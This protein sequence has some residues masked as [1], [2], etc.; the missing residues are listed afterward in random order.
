L[1]GWEV[2]LERLKAKNRSAERLD[3]YSPKFRDHL[4]PHSARGVARHHASRARQLHKRPLT[5]L[6]AY[7]AN[8][9]TRLAHAIYNWAGRE[10]GVETEIESISGADLFN[11]EKDRRRA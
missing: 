1:E 3:D 7:F 4:A 2:Y 8:G 11:P 9:A 6:A 5:K 10:L